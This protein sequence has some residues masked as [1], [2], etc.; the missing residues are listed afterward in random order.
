MI[1][2]I[3]IRKSKIPNLFSFGDKITYGITF[4][5]FIFITDFNKISKE[6]VTPYYNMD[7]VINHET[8]H[9]QQTIETGVVGFYLIYLIE[10][11]YK[12]IKHKNIGK[13]YHRI[14]FEREAYKHMKQLNYISYRKRY[15]W[16][17][18]IL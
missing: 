7:E 15:S 5:P 3:I 10:F 14:S 1:K 16:L 12:L 11:I 8:I 4:F 17:K 18:Y 13:A 6:S 9:F 2:P